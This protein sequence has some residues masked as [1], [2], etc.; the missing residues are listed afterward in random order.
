MTIIQTYKNKVSVSEIRSIVEDYLITKINANREVFEAISRMGN[1][2]GGNVFPAK[3][4][5]TRKARKGKATPDPVAASVAIIQESPPDDSEN[6]FSVLYLFHERHQHVGCTTYLR[7]QEILLA[8][9]ADPTRTPLGIYDDKTELFEWDPSLRSEFDRA[10]IR[11]QGAR[12]HE[13]IS[14]A[15]ALRRRDS[16]WESYE[17]RRPS[18]FS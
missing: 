14:I 11:E 4:Y 15:Q 5:T 9:S 12:G 16:S 18:V 3:Y 6:R 8:L 10:E 17:F 2:Y 1:Y 7:A 13:I